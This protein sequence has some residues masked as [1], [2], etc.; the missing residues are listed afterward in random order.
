MRIT[1]VKIRHVRVPM[2]RAVEFAWIP[3][4]KIS[5]TGFTIVEIHTDEGITGI[6]ASNLVDDIQVA[7]SIRSLFKPYLIGKDPFQVETHMEALANMKPFGAPPWAISQALWDLVGKAAGQPLYRLWGAARNKIRAYAAPAEPRDPAAHREIASRYLSDGFHA[8]KLRLHNMKLEDDIAV[9]EAV[10]EV[11]GS[12]MEILV[13]ANQALKL[14]S[15]NPHPYWDFRRALASAR[16]LEKLNVFYLEEPL[17]MY[18]FEGLRRLRQLTSLYIAG[19]ECNMGIAD[20]VV[21]LEKDCYD[22]LQPDAALSESMHQIRRIAAMAIA[23][24][25]ICMPHT[26]GNGIGLFANFQIALTLPEVRSPFFEYPFDYET[27]PVEVGQAGIANPLRPDAEGFILA[28]EGPGLGFTL[29][30]ELIE[31]HTVFEA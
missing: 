10:R 26:W 1:D 16:A 19:G 30:Q 31:R 25:K 5:T 24:G 13:D 7:V 27:W 9:V 3:G 2:K 22:V 20:F 6:G 8:V 21:L 4:T 29:D 12:K 11:V 17:E 23:R 18:D 28:P 15:V 14:P